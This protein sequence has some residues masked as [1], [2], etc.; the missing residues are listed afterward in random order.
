MTSPPRPGL[1]GRAAQPIGLA[2]L[3]AVNLLVTFA[4]QWLPVTALGVG[5]ETDALFVSAIIPQVL[6]NVAGS[7]LP[8]VLT[9][10]LATAG[11][12][13]RQRAWTYLQG[14]A[15]A[16]IAATGILVILA[17]Y[18]SPWLAP[19][20]DPSARALTA[21]LVR[22]QLLGAWATTVLMVAWAVNYAAHRF[23]WVE[24]SGIV[25]GL[26]GL[27]VGWLGVGPL[28]V[29]AWAWAMTARALVHLVLCLPALGRY[30]RPDWSES[31]GAAVGRRLVPLVAG[32]VYFKLD[33]L[34]DRLL[35]SFGPSGQLSVFHLANLAYAAGNQILTRALV[36]PVMPGLATLAHA[37]GG[38]AP[39]E[40]AVRRRL[41]VVQGLAL[42]AWLGLLA[43]GRPVM[44]AALGRWMRPA[45][46]DLLVALMVALLGVWLGGAAGQV[47]T[48][49]FFAMGETATPTRV[50]VAGFTAAIPLKLLAYRWFGIE[51]LAVAA[52]IY[53]VGTAMAH[54]VFLT[55]ALRAHW[56]GADGRA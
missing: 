13:F 51:G 35:A 27:L 2:G 9:P 7:G 44:H 6:A 1:M 20:F 4:Y 14:T 8:S 49:A 50:G 43:V 48:V 40:R 22:V 29:V 56:A 12:R 55:R 15:L 53:Y 37:P 23:V 31:E 54:H 36:N 47:L 25:A 21:S 19:G 11:D 18:W 34:V 33:P 42:A 41:V 16:A 38:R 39:F 45:E 24:A 5:I 26:A 3:A 30:A 10:M 52:S 32:A 28:G 46:I 17:P